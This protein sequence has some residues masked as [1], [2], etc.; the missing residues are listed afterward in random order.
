MSQMIIKRIPNNME[1]NI[2]NVLKINIKFISNICL[3]NYQSLYNYN[4]YKATF[5]I[6]K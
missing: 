4:I 2:K 6:Y 1:L 3:S 5:I